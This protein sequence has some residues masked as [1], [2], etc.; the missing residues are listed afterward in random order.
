MLHPDLPGL[1]MET[2]VLN[3]NA[4][5]R[6]TAKAINEQAT[7][8]PF[9]LYFTPTLALMKLTPTGKVKYFLEFPQAVGVNKTQTIEALSGC[10]FHDRKVSHSGCEE[11]E[12]FELLLNLTAQ[13]QSSVTT[14]LPSST[15]CLSGFHSEGLS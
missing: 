8:F 3:E 9:V 5:L 14:F 4:V 1:K 11:K 12:P 2:D 7:S 15:W 6:Q 13:S 10:R